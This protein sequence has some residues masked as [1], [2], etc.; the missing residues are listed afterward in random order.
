MDVNDI[1]GQPEEIII[2]ETRYVEPA[3]SP[4]D[5]VNA[6]NYNK[7]NL[8]VDDWSEKQYVPYIVN[9]ALSYGADTVIPAN[10]MNSRPHIDK[11]LQFDYLRISVRPRKRFSK[12]LKPEQDDRIDALKALYGY[13]NTRAREVV[14]LL[15]EDD[16][17]QIR[18]LLDQGG[19]KL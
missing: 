10:E 9:K 8:I 18:T 19:A 6:I 2:P 3:I 7:E 13:S 12:W 11:K 4:F 5:F 15:S 1:F 17:K 16:W 14:D